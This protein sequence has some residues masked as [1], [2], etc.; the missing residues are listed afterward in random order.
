MTQQGDVLLQQF[1]AVLDTIDYGVLFMGPDLR[2]KIINRKFREIWHIPDEFIRDTRPTMADLI[3]FN[4]HNGI[5]DVAETD[6]DAYVERRVALVLSG[7]AF[8]GEV[9]L[10][11]G[12]VIHHQIQ[13]LPDGG[14]L[15]TYFDITNLKRSEEAAKQAR[16]LAETTLAERGVLFDQFNAVLETVDYAVLFMGPDLRSKI[17]NR[18]FKEMWGISEEFIRDVRP[19]MA[20]LVRFVHHNHHLY[21]VS[22]DDFEAFLARRVEIAIEGNFSTEMRLRDGRVIHFQIQSLSDGGRLLTYFDISELK[23]SEEA[24]KKAKDAAEVALAEL[25]F[26]QNRLIQTEKLASLGQLTAGIAHEIKNPL[27]FINN[28]SALSTELIDELQETLRK[29]NLSKELSVEVEELATLLRG[30]LD[31]VQQHGKRADAIV[32]NMLMH[33]REST[34]ERRTASI[35]AIIEDSLN[36]AYYGARAEKKDF[37]VSLHRSFDPE[38]GDVD[39]YPQDITRAVLNLISNSLYALIRR[40]GESGPSY[41][42][43]LAASTK[44]IGDDRV[45]IRIRDN[46]GGISPEIKDRIFN[47]FFTTK[48]PGEGTGL[49]LSLSYD[50]IVKQHAGSIEFE[51]QHGDFTEFRV[52]LPRTGKAG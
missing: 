51:T 50:I 26:A 38:A 28:F 52:V 44:D 19:T 29:G 32:K 42:P 43:T 18:A 21:D 24:A 33:S 22:D 2:S 25:K 47:P 31:K 27:N 23:R 15:L 37:E 36:L 20:D 3:N 41:E 11:D 35:N 48:P 1:N 40:N 45:E 8:Q 17:I 4:R 9:R 16:Q 30:N 5:Y 10:R 49:G 12:R 39:M 7:A 6:F 34:G 14:R 46:G 13:A